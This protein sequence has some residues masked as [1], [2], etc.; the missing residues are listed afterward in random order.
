MSS[1]KRVTLYAPAPDGAAFGPDAFAASLGQ[2]VPVQIPA[3]VNGLDTYRGRITAA[4]VDPDGAGVTL[5]LDLVELIR[6][7]EAPR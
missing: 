2:L 3:G 1:P 4:T 7:E 6:T 5:T